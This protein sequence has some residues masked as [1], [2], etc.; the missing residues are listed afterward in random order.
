MNPAG[1]RVTASSE[2]SPPELDFHPLLLQLVASA[3]YPGRLMASQRGGAGADRPGVDLTTP[4]VST[5][6]LRTVAATVG[7]SRLPLRRETV[8]SY[9]VH[10][11]A[12][13]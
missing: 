7:S 3:Q 5:R 13:R 9:I 8:V 4:L 1:C 10:R 12:A 6:T 2:S 11:N